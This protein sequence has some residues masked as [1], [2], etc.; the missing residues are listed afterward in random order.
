[1]IGKAFV[2]SILALC[3]MSL[4]DLPLI[5]SRGV[6]FFDWLCS[7]STRNIQTGYWPWLNLKTLISFTNMSQTINPKTKPI[8]PENI[9]PSA[10]TDISLKNTWHKVEKSECN[11][12]PCRRSSDLP[13]DEAT[14]S[15]K[16]FAGVFHSSIGSDRL[17]YGAEIDCM[18]Q[19][20]SPESEFIELKVCAGKSLNDLPFQQ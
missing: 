16:E 8:W 19:K 9:V 11:D 6:V 3:F 5:F 1:M 20:E 12:H 15:S 10:T 18:L 14:N 2:H 13:A 7:V 17:L 4:L